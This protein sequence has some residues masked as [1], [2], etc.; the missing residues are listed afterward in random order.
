[1]LQAMDIFVMPSLTETTSLA[2]LEAMSSGLPVVATKVGFIKNYLVKDHNG[3][4]FARRNSGMLS[5]K[6]ERLLNDDELRK[7]LGANARKTVAY[8]L[9]WERS[10]NKI[11]KILTDCLYKE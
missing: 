11:T 6:L 2:T 10:I 7:K 4:F 3:E 1:Y 5:L 9:S 8:S